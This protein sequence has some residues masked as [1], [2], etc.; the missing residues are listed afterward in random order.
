M[1]RHTW[2]LVAAP[3]QPSKAE[4]RS[5]WE[6]AWGPRVAAPARAARRWRR[7][8]LLLLVPMAAGA[9]LASFVS[10]A[11]DTAQALPRL[12]PAALDAATNTAGVEAALAAMLTERI[13]HAV[14]VNAAPFLNEMA[15]ATRTATAYSLLAPLRC[16]GRK[17]ELRH[18]FRALHV[19]GS[20]ALAI[21]LAA[22]AHTPHLDAVTLVLRPA[23]IW[24][25]AWKLAEVAFIEPAQ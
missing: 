21:S 7:I 19:T 2:P 18:S 15:T 3:A 11:L 17:S 13:T 4:G 16:A 1:M 8:P 24:P 22:C 23:A 14:P 12:S 5:G 20:G 9:F 6:T 10:S 25:P